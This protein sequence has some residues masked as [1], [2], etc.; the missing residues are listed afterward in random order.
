M[1]ETDVVVNVRMVVPIAHRTE[2]N[3]SFIEKL[4]RDKVVDI[5]NNANQ[6][7][8]VRYTHAFMVR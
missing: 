7:I 4:A 6:K 2:D 5:I 3:V 1:E 8:K